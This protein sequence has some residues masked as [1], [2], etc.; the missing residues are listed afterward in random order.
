M[1]TKNEISRPGVPD[2]GEHVPMAW[3]SRH[4]RVFVAPCPIGKGLFAEEA[5]RNGDL[6]MK[7]NGPHYGRE[8][9]I[10]LRE[11]GANL[12]Q[13]GLRSY[14]LLQPPG[15]FA[16]HSCNPNAG[17]VNN[18]RLIAIRDIMAGEE[19]CFDYSTTMEEEFWTLQCC[20]GEAN[21]RGLITDFKLLPD[22]VREKYLMLGIV[23]GFIKRK[24]EFRS[25]G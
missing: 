10:H 2:T 13:T 23:Q 9:P 21:C 25:K 6:I 15:V 12:L 1:K 7:L 18:R 4:G 16:N 17:I 22:P 3:R 11:E 20:C 14:I 19:I 8:D 5:F 24:Q